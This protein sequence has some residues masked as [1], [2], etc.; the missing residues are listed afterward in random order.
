MPAVE[1]SPAG[2]ASSEAE[3]PVAAAASNAVVRTVTICQNN[4]MI[5]LPFSA[6]G[7]G[8]DVYLHWVQ[9]LQGHDGVASIHCPY[10]SLAVLYLKVR[11]HF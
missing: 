1:A 6:R 11:L 5:I 4:H 8:S 9:G 2:A 7:S 3:P 10:K